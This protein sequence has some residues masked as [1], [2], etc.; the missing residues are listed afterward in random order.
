MLA[1]RLLIQCLLQ[2]MLFEK[3]SKEWG[4][5]RKKRE[6]AHSM[7]EAQKASVNNILGSLNTSFCISSSAT[8]EEICKVLYGVCH[9]LI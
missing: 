4:R 6:G 7:R 5:E 8:E 1:I 9:H 3:S 2:S